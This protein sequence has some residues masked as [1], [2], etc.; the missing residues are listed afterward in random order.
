MMFSRVLNA[1]T[2]IMS[3]LRGT[4]KFVTRASTT[5]NVLPGSRYRLVASRSRAVM[6]PAPLSADGSQALSKLRTLVVP[7]AI[8]RPPLACVRLMASTVFCGTV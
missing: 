4:W 3:V 7:T 2:S 1:L 5:W 8:T 6:A